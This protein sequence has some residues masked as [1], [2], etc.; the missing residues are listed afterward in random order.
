MLVQ[1]IRKGLLIESSWCVC[2]LR[3]LSSLKRRGFSARAFLWNGRGRLDSAG[4]PGHSGEGGG[5]AFLTLGLLWRSLLV[6]RF[7]Y[8]FQRGRTI[9][10]TLPDSSSLTMPHSKPQDMGSAFIQTQQLN[11]AMADTFLEHM[12]LLDIDSEP[13]TAR[14]TGIIC[15]I[16]PAS[17]SV[18]MLKEM[19]KSGMNIARLNFSHGSHEYHGETI[20]NIREAT[21]SFEPGSIH[22]RPIGIALDT[23]G[24]EIR[25]GLIKGSG[26]AEVEL[27]KGNTIKVTLDDAYMENCDEDVLWLDYKNITK[28]VEIGS[29][30][31]IDDGLIS[32][33]VQEIGSDY[34]LCEIE[35]GGTLGSKKGVNLPGAAVDLPAVSEK[36]IKDLQFGVEMG[37]DMVFASFIRKAQD[38]NEVRQVLGEKGKNIKIISK[39]E[40][41]EGV[42]RFDEI[43][44]AS[45]GIMV[46]R[47][48]LGIEI[49]TEKVFLAQKMMIGRCNRAGKPI[50]CATQML[51]SMIKK[52]RPTRAEG[53]DVANAVLDG[54]DCIMLSGETAKGDYPLEAVRTQHMIAR[55][56]EAAMFHRQVFEDL[57]RCTPHS[58]DPAE[59]IAIGA[60]EASFKL[61][62]PAFIVLTGSG[63]SAHLISR[64]RPRA[65]IIAVTRNGQ[66]ARQAH[67]YRGIFPVFYNK[68]AH[69]VWA[70]D[71]D[72]RV[73][74][75]MDVGKA[76]GF[77]KTGDVVIVLTG[78]RPGSGFTNTMRVVPVP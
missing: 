77:F 11:A 23:K 21:E 45:D 30:V 41:H 52:P 22:Y 13:T 7:L 57:R 68:P 46:A 20:K 33:Q 71:V 65:P 25:T 44:E 64:Y 26:T 5:R 17:R 31:Y 19:I 15:T 54:A 58:T 16:G 37:V 35:N 73:N 67:L 78:W 10:R 48:D 9:Y 28:V 8:G 36:D 18:D 62:A 75:A 66:T 56:A 32:L 72:L 63:R 59:A 29:K 42:R 40:N 69:D 4:L 2:S 70:E 3:S 55:E 61:L 60:V 51:E 24:P 39:L 12:C 27:K 1:R 50:T 49:P 43:M 53:S 76:R 34:I 6:T 74:F 38:V 14:N 47:G